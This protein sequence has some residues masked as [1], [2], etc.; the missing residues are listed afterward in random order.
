M[1]RYKIAQ[2]DRALPL[3]R[4]SF[5]REILKRASSNSLNPA[6]KEMGSPG[7]SSVHSSLPNLTLIVVYHSALAAFNMLPVERVILLQSYGFCALEISQEM[8]DV[9]Y[10]C[11]TPAIN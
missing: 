7:L 3:S 8:L 5:M 4:H 10:I 1:L 9:L 2:S 6:Y 11:T